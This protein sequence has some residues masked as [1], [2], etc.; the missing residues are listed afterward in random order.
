MAGTPG[1]GRGAGDSAAQE[2]IKQVEQIEYLLHQSTLGVNF[3]FDNSE[4]AR[5][6]GKDGEGS[7][8]TSWI[9]GI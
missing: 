8:P 9:Y 5:V 7:E 6:M 2:K 1:E 4:I 3:I